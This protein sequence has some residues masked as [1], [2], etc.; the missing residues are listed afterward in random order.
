MEKAPSL[1]D[2]RPLSLFHLLHITPREKAHCLSDSRPL[3]FLYRC[4]MQ[5]IKRRHP[6]YQIGGL[7][8]VPISLLYATDVEEAP[9]L[10]DWGPLSRSYLAAICN[11]LWRRHPL[12]Q[13][14]ICYIQIQEMRHTVCQIRGLSLSYLAAICNCCREGTLSVRLEASLSF[15]FAT[16]NSCGEGTLSVRFEASLFPI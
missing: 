3:S 15:Q 14:P 13:I 5:L 9:S 10:S 16:C 6:L 7:S 11:S 2:S 1:S 4:Y 12:C 8:L